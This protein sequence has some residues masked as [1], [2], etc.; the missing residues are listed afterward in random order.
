MV[1]R[2]RPQPRVRARPHRRRQRA[3]A[4]HATVALGVATLPGK[5]LP[6]WDLLL[7]RRALGA[8]TRRSSFFNSL[9]LNA[10]RRAPIRSAAPGIRINERRGASP[11]R[12]APRRLVRPKTEP[13]VEGWQP[14]AEYLQAAALGE[15]EEEWPGQ[16]AAKEASFNTVQPAPPEVADD[17]SL[18]D[19]TV[20]EIEKQKRLFAELERQRAAAAAT[21]GPRPATRRPRIPLP[22]EPRPYVF[23]KLDASDSEDEAA[24][25]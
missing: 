9:L 15:Q 2:A 18:T 3:P 11:G 1:E 25:A 14:P 4:Y 19:F 24:G 21:A 23:I 6:L 17:W 7:L 13:A 8:S 5:S 20:E 16:R 22:P 12:P 10:G